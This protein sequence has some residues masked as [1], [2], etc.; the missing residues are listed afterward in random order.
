M[1]DVHLFTNATAAYDASRFC[2]TL[3]AA[4]FLGVSN[5]TV[6]LWVENGTLRA[7][8]TAGGHRRIS[9][10]SIEKL[11]GI[12]QYAN[13]VLQVVQDASFRRK[14]LLV[15]QDRTLLSLY[16]VEMSR[17]DIPMMIRKCFDGY[18]ALIQ[19]GEMRPHLLI[20]DLS[21]SG[22]DVQ[23]MIR[24]LRENATHGEIAIIVTSGL[25][26]NTGNAIGLSNGFA[27]LTKP[28]LF[29]QLKIAVELAL[30][31]SSAMQKR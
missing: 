19:I 25:E 23:R 24:S 17:W 2:S 15:D 20:I 7:W 14:V 29:D 1:K 18:E 8:K 9:M 3:K 13:G 4:N 27:V 16:E 28:V 11:V 6:Q 5:R 22:M 10:D 21:I 26:M 31:A 30:K 12:R